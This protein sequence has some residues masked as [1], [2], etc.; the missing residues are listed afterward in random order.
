MLSETKARGWGHSAAVALNLQLWEAML[1]PSHIG[2]MFLGTQALTANPSRSYQMGPKK[3]LPK[4]ILWIP[5]VNE[6]FSSVQLTI[7]MHVNSSC[8][9]CLARGN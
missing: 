1:Q 8:E 4:G 9:L 3:L 5:Q 2:L 6:L 7:H